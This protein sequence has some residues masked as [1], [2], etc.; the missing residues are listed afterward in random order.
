MKSARETLKPEEIE[1]LDRRAWNLPRPPQQPQL[2]E[3]PFAVQPG[4]EDKT[5]AEPEVA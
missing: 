3:P 4:R 2:H 5:E 1:V